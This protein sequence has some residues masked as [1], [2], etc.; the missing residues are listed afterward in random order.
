MVDRECLGWP[1]NVCD[2]TTK[3]CRVKTGNTC[4]GMISLP[5]PYLFVFFVGWGCVYEAIHRGGRSM[6]SYILRVVWYRVTR[7]GVTR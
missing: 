3:M 7:R 6:C 4:I 2:P 1:D 5:P